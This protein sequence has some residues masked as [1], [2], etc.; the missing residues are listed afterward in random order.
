MCAAI[1]IVKKVIALEQSS[2]VVMSGDDSAVDGSN[3]VQKSSVCCGGSGG[4]EGRDGEE[5][6][7]ESIEY[8]LIAYVEK[9]AR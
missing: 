3:D 8:E 5:K 6:E 9:Y 4:S 7:A 1:P 2:C